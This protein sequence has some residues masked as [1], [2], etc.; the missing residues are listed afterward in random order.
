MYIAGRNG[1]QNL[2]HKTFMWRYQALEVSR[3]SAGHHSV[4]NKSLLPLS[5]GC[6]I[7]CLLQP[8]FYVLSRFT[9]PPSKLTFPLF[10][11]DVFS[12]LTLMLLPL[13][14]QITHVLNMMGS[15]TTF[16]PLQRTTFFISLQPIQHAFGWGPGRQRRTLCSPNFPKQS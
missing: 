2:G 5:H 12:L 9:C 15:I 7:C 10:L 3:R 14:G 4:T 6:Y 11:E 16:T 8:K 1:S 13:T